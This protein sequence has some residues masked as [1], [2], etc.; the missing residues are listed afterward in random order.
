[1][2]AKD[3]NPDTQFVVKWKSPYG[4]LLTSGHNGKGFMD[5]PQYVVIMSD[6][7]IR[8]KIPYETEIEDYIEG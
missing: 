3:L 8:H 2:K 1:M 6:A 5:D 4:V 7:G